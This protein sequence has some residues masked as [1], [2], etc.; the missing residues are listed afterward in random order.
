MKKIVSIVVL[1][2]A[3][4]AVKAQTVEEV[5]NKHIDAIGGAAALDKIESVVKEGSLNANGY[6]VALT[7]TQ[8]KDKGYRMDISVMGMSAYQI[9][10]PKE[11]WSF[12]P[13]NG[14]T[15]PRSLSEAELKD[16]Q[17]Q[18][19]VHSVLYNYA[20]K[21][22]K[23]ELTGSEKAEGRDCFK[24][25]VVTA[26]GKNRTYFIDKATYL[27]VKGVSMNKDKEEEFIFSN[28]KPIEGVQFA[29]TIVRPQG[30][31]NISKITVNSKI[32]ESIFKLSK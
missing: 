21:G 32:D 7:L 20:K 31:L 30:E 15:E 1:F 4:F 29:H 14:E 10:T 6:D 25:N 22:H 17:D 8:L 3:T 23:V 26:S 11:G 5:V 2:I 9:I 18:L 28:Y 24:L 13:F 19:D 16:G 27:L 12:M